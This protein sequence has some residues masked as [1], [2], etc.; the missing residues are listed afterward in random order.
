M[1]INLRAIRVDGFLCSPQP[2]SGENFRPANVKK[3]QRFRIVVLKMLMILSIMDF[4]EGF[5]L[6][7]QTFA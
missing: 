2:L 6:L 3:H 4:A 7:R 5:E 1:A